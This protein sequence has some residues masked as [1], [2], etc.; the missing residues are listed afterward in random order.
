M[1]SLGVLAVLVAMV[2]A[3]VLFLRPGAGPDAATASNAPA[4]VDKAQAAASAAELAQLTRAIQ[5]F[6]AERERLPVGLE[7]LQEAGYIARIP[8]RVRYD[9]PSG[10]VFP[11]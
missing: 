5:R 7:E 6:R 1:K 4:L 10:R 9:A 8:A 3:L 11:E 2:V